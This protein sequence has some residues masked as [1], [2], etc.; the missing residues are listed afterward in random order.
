[1]DAVSDNGQKPFRLT[2][3]ISA[4][5]RSDKKDTGCG[6][7]IEISTSASPTDKLTRLTAMVKNL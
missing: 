1:M 4:Y 2:R 5:Y 6:G 7:P 3:R